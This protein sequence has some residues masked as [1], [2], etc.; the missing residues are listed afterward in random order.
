MDVITLAEGQQVVVDSGHL[1]AYDET[2]K[3]QSAPGGRR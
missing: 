1:V 2:V 3:E